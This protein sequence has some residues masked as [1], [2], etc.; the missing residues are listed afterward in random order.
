MFR[1]QLK[2]GS[3]DPLAVT[4]CQ[5]VV[6]EA[7]FIHASSVKSLRSSELSSGIDILCKLLATKSGQLPVI[8]D[9]TRELTFIPEVAASLS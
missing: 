3:T 7:G 1:Y 6:I 2:F 4:V 9:S 8:P 5:S